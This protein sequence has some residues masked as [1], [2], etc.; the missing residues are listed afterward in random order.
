MAQ[1]NIPE[2]HID[3]F[4]LYLDLQ[5][6]L[7]N[8]LLQGLKS[9][10]GNLDNRELV[11][12]LAN[13]TT[14]D[15]TQL[16]NIVVIYTALVHSENA[17]DGDEGEFMSILVTSLSNLRPDLDEKKIFLDLEKLLSSNHSLIVHSKVIN[18]MM[19]NP[20]SFLSARIYQDLKSSFGSNGNLMGSVIVHNLKLTVMEGQE[21]KEIFISLDNKDLQK[22]LDEVKKAQENTKLISSTFPNA[23]IINL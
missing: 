14:L 16:L 2:Q 20:R 13:K 5:D 17:F 19:E 22:L 12:Y 8:E 6:S 4:L 3:F 15:K 11:E 21:E 1:L 18:L 9:Y 7:K 10:E 23:N